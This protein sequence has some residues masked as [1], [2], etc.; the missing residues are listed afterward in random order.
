MVYHPR[1]YTQILKINILYACVPTKQKRPF[2]RD[3][4]PSSPWMTEVRRRLSEWTTR[5]FCQRFWHG[6]FWV[7]NPWT[8]DEMQ[9]K[10][11]NIVQQHNCCNSR[12]FWNW[13]VSEE[14]AKLRNLL[15]FLLYKH[16]FCRVIFRIWFISKRF[17]EQDTRRWLSCFF[18]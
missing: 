8:F 11:V 10:K 6:H 5:T 2:C 12:V 4:T 9:I 1:K 18:S 7:E 3:L 13:W 15:Q 17:L 16:F 14:V